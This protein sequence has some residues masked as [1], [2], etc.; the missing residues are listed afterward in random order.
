MAAEHRPRQHR[1]MNPEKVSDVL[2]RLVIAWD[3]NQRAAMEAAI[4]DARRLLGPLPYRESG[5]EG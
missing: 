5:D 2:R 3:L 4:T 1:I